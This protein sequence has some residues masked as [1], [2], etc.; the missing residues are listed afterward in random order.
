M[1]KSKICGI[2]NLEDALQ[3]ID[4]GAD[5]LGFVFYEKSKRHI[6]IDSAAEIISKLPPFVE[7]VALFVNARASYINSTCK[8]CGAT[9]AQIHFESS[10]ENFYKKLE[11]PYINVIRAQCAEDI[12]KF[13]DEY[14]LVDAYCESYGGSGK[15]VNL[16]WF[17]NR[18]NSKII[19]AGGLDEHNV[20][21]V[22]KYGFYGVDVSS[23]TESSYGKK[24][25]QKVSDF[26]KN[27]KACS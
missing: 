3:A 12:D 26:I 13:S 15:R 18:D 11:V 19:L 22:Q 14:R 7:K 27:A 24:D 10:E 4:A 20:Q 16:E 1:L 17:E 2:T 5:A 21:E 8:A 25:A 23:S 6:S 9:L